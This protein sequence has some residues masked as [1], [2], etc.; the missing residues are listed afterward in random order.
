MRF[1]AALVSLFVFGLVSTA[2]VS[3]QGEEASKAEAKK[4]DVLKDCKCPM[5]GRD[6]DK[7]KFVAYKD[8]KVYMC[9][10][11]CVKGFAKASKKPEVA[12]KANHQLV[13]TKQVKQVKCAL[14]GKGKVNEK[15]KIKVA[16]AEVN[17]C[18]KNCL[19]KVAKME[20]KD[21]I[22][23]LFTTASFDKAFKLMKK[24][25]KKEKAGA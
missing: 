17:F 9:C 1:R 5:S 11:N 4:E 23:T 22:K 8:A 15:A 13:M 14:N 24:D 19:G 12:M 18:C 2:F 3:A 10:G 16:G 7:E 25:E 6:I 20:E 21:Q